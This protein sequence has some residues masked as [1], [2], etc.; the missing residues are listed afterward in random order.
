M[1]LATSAIECGTAREGTVRTARAGKA[2]FAVTNS[3]GQTL[4]HFSDFRCA[5]TYAH[6]LTVVFLP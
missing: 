5:S 6:D 1:S 3:I 2:G 4:M